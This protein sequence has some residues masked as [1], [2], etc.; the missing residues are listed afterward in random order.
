MLEGATR[1]GA[2]PHPRGPPLDPLAWFSSSVCVIFSKNISR[3]GLEN[4][5]RGSRGGPRGWGRAPLPRARPPAS[6]SPRASPGA[7]LLPI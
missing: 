6:W 7:L 2:R 4:D 5:V 1:Q 3:E